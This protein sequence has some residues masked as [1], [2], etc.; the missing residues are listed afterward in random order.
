MAIM[1]IIFTSTTTT[2]LKFADANIIHDGGMT[3]VWQGQ[4]K[5]F[6]VPTANVVAIERIV[7]PPPAETAPEPAEDAS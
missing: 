1:R 2:D 7:P 3:T 4:E 5:V 6:G